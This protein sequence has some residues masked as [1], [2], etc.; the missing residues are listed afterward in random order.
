[1]PGRVLAVQGNKGELD[2]PCF[3]DSKSP[4]IVRH[5]IIRGTTKRNYVPQRKYIAN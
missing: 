2:M 3:I 5:I 4:L 1:M